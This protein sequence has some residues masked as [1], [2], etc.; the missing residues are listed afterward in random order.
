MTEKLLQYIWNFKIFENFDFRDVEG[1]ALEILEF[2]KWNHDSGPDFSMGKIRQNGVE[3][4]GNIE[5]H[6]RSSDWILHNHDDDSAYQNVILH[7][8]FLHDSEVESLINKGIPTI[9]LKNYISAEAL[10]KFQNFDAATQF[11]PC[12]KIF[13][14]EKIPFGFAENSLLKKLS[15]KSQLL[16]ERLQN[17]GNNYEALMFQEIAAAFGLKINSEIFR[18]I[19]ENLPFSVIQKVRQNPVQL[20]ALLF[21]KAGWLENPPDEQTKIW[22]K[23]YNFLQTKFQLSGEKITPKFLRLRPPNF[24]TIRLSQLAQLYYREP[25]LFSKITEAESIAELYRI[26]DGIA[27]SEYW[28]DKFNFGK[29]S[30]L[31]PKNLSKSFIDLVLINSVLPVKFFYNLNFR[32]DIADSIL[33]F[34]AQLQPEKNSVIGNWKS[35]KISVKNALES[36]AYNYH[37]KTMCLPKNCLNCSIGL[38]LLKP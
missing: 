19:A 17:N 11:I 28:D 8:V 38:Q 36:Q 35:L 24:P 37:Y 14:P 27:A 32:E 18:Q 3:I 13:K 20:E 33:D 7:A 2:G 9:E 21:G 4:V 34:Y 23:E 25:N 1:H 26:F 10:R 15:E 31:S 29:P 22:Q 12:E 6:L 30:S 5:L 16:S